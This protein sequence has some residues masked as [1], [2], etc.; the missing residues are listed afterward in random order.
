MIKEEILQLNSKKH[1]KIWKL[2]KLGLSNKEIASLLGTGVG[3][4]FNVLKEY[5]SKPEKATI[6]EAL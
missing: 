4:V 1:I 2:H 5:N 3:H 6:A